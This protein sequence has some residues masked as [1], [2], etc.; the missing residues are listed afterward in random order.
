MRESGIGIKQLKIGEVERVERGWN[1]HIM[2][3]KEY[4]GREIGTCRSHVR[5]QEYD[6]SEIWMLFPCAC[7]RI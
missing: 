5:A 7:K 4:D 3:A 1:H 6:T 2:C